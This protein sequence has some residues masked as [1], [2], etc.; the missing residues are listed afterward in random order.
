MLRSLFCRPGLVQGF[1]L[2]TQHLP[3][4][5]VVLTAAHG[6]GDRK[7]TGGAGFLWARGSCGLKY[8]LDRHATVNTSGCAGHNIEHN[9]SNEHYNKCSRRI[10]KSA[11]GVMNKLKKER[12]TLGH[13][14]TER[15]TEQL[16][17]SVGWAEGKGGDTANKIFTETDLEEIH[18][19]FISKKPYDKDLSKGSF[20]QEMMSV[21]SGDAI[22]TR[23]ESWYCPTCYL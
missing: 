12:A 1:R 3:G 15:I 16:E 14:T 4:G 8:R 23:P 13:N 9:L 22:K 2:V 21:Y 10:W 19:Q 5:E 7:Q 20:N 6:R 17:T 11:N 18:F